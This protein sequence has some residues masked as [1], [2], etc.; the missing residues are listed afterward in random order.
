MMNHLLPVYR[1]W[2]MHNWLLGQHK[3]VPTLNESMRVELQQIVTT[4]LLGPPICQEYAHLVVQSLEAYWSIPISEI[5]IGDLPL[6]EMCQK[7][8]D[9]L[10]DDTLARFALS[11]IALLMFSD[12]LFSSMEEDLVGDVWWDACLAVLDTAP[13]DYLGPERTLLLNARIQTKLRGNQE[14]IG[15]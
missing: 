2:S 13:R 5:Q 10:S 7:G 1:V 12:L 11:P 14:D 6:E 9:V 8:L 4:A 15:R 3:P